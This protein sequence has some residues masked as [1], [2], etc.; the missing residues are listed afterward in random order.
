MSSPP[1]ERTL[2]ALARFDER[3]AAVCRGKFDYNSAFVP[4]PPNSGWLALAF[5]EGLRRDKQAWI[6]SVS[7]QPVRG[8]FASEATSAAV[9][10]FLPAPLAEWVSAYCRRLPPQ[11]VCIEQRFDV[12]SKIRISAGWV[13]FQVGTAQFL[14]E[15]A[16]ITMQ[17]EAEGDDLLIAVEAVSTEKVAEDIH[18]RGNFADLAIAER[19]VRANVRVAYANRC[20]IFGAEPNQDGRRPNRESGGLDKSHNAVLS[21]AATLAGAGAIYGRLATGQQRV[22]HCWQNRDAPLQIVHFTYGSRADGVY[23]PG[24]Q[25]YDVVRLN[26]SLRDVEHWLS[27]PIRAAKGRANIVRVEHRFSSETGSLGSKSLGGRREYGEQ[28]RNVTRLNIEAEVGAAGLTLG[29]EAELTGVIPQTVRPGYP[30][31]E[32]PKSFSAEVTVPWES[33]ILAHSDIA[34][35]RDRFIEK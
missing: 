17:A 1:L 21:A 18:A 9:S 8:V 19:L 26:I 28:R 12:M 4:P 25:L 13:R 11:E 30:I 34:H 29:V 31:E 14:Q 20:V 23:D 10:L 27:Q 15:L 24:P 16:S 3:G 7:N 2:P 5:G 22:V 6:H 35:F 33:L 32:E